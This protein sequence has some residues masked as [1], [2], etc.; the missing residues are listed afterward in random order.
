ME[1]YE[2][3]KERL[4]LKKEGKTAGKYTGLDDDEFAA[5]TGQKSGILAK[6]DADLPEADRSR[7]PDVEG[8][9]L[10]AAFTSARR[11]EEEEA[12]AFEAR[13][14]PVVRTAES[15]QD[16]AKELNKTLASLDYNS[17]FSSWYSGIS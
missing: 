9:R 15:K 13:A 14:Q 6:Y 11:D 3:T 10:G 2:R 12:A 5:K 8:F 7:Q 16:I 1:D 17:A 4:R